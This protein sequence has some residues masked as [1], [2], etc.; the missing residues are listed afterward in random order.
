MKKITLLAVVLI[1]ASFASCKKNYTCS[2]SDTD[3]YSAD[4]SLGKQT[5]KNAQATCD[6]YDAAWDNCTLK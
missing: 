2:C 4:Y 5:K 6:S 3:G 1:A